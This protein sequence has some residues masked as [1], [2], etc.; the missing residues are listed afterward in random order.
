MNHFQKPDGSLHSFEDG[1]AGDLITPDMLPITQAQFDALTAPNFEV[2]KKAELDKFRTDR[3]EM[4]SVIVG[5]GWAAGEN[6][7]TATVTALLAFREGLKDL[8]TWP[9]VV[10]AT[11]HIGL[12]TAMAARYKTLNDALPAAIKAG[13]KNLYRPS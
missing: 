3:K 5:M 12:K 1:Y 13:F 8:P 9:A 6:N 11:T 2:L 4:F 7:D 10:A